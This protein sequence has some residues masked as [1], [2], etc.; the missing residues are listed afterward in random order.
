MGRFSWTI[1]P[2]SCIV[3][4][5][6]PSPAMTQTSPIRLAKARRSQWQTKPHRA[7][8][9]GG[10]DGVGNVVAVELAVHTE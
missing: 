8:A 5:K 3:I 9:T 2:R 1:V 4:W 7:E 6:P 10:D